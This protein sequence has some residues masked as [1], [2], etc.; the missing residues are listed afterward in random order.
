MGRAELEESGAVSDT[1]LNAVA[2]FAAEIGGDAERLIA[3]LRERSDPRFKGYR[4]TSADDLER[5]F[6]E[7]GYLDESQIL[8]ES[9]ILERAIETPAASQI[10]V[11]TEARLLHEWWILSE[12]AASPR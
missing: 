8:G 6:M 10:S 11:E 3:A 5:F 4:D 12:P 1:H 9:E 7:S 2:E